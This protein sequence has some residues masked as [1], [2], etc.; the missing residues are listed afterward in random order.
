M[1]DE[2]IT[3]R[4]TQG[5]LALIDIAEVVSASLAGAPGSETP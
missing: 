5:S 1:L 2:G 3:A 4:D